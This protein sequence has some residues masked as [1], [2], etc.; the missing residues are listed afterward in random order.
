MKI[1]DLILKSNYKIFKTFIMIKYYFVC[2]QSLDAG[3]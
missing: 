1:T 3:S 2:V